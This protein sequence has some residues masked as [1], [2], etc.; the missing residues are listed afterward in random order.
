MLKLELVNHGYHVGKNNVS[1]IVKKCGYRFWKAKEVLTSNDPNYKEK[2]EAITKILS[3]LKPTE[4][5]FSIDEF[6]PFA[7]KERGGKRLVPMGE[8]PTVPQF[9][10]SRGSLIVTA[11][12]EL[13]TNQI[14]HF[15]STGK[16]SDEIIRM[17]RILITK[18][19][20]C[21]RIFLSWDH[22]SWNSSKS[23]L[24][25]IAEV[26]S[27]SFR[28]KAK[29]PIVELA[30]LPARSQFLNVIESVFS[31]MAKAIIQNSDYESVDDAKVAIDRYFKERNGHFRKHP[32]R[33]GRK[34]SS[35]PLSRRV[36]IARTPSPMKPNSRCGSDTS[37]LG[38]ASGLLALCA[39]VQGQHD[40]AI[41]WWLRVSFPAV[42]PG[43]PSRRLTPSRKT[44]ID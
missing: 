2:L 25:E 17:L 28:K 12:L 39:S 42:C 16:N 34:I 32:K 11:A 37:R 9:Q 5:F 43:Q 40:E 29:T 23:L 3:N 26:N 8:Y 18:Y 36:R 15:Y 21:R 31:G 22:A 19:S 6:G 20:G 27:Y 7:V 44:I 30:P 10:R 4:R 33:A 14:T 1:K 24:S 35:F 41:L 13:S 38:P